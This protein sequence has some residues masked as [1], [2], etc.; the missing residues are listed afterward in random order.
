MFSICRG[1]KLMHYSS[2]LICMCAW[3]KKVR[4]DNGLW[5][6]FGVPAGE[7]VVTHGICPDCAR[8]IR[9]EMSSLCRKQ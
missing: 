7:I 5:G 1:G 6:E 9:L 4:N 3:C 2:S 8:G